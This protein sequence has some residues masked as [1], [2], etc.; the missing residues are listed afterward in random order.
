MSK[1]RPDQTEL[2]ETQSVVFLLLKKMLTL[3]CNIQTYGPDVREVR[4]NIVIDV[5][6]LV[7]TSSRPIFPSPKVYN[8]YNIYP[9]ISFDTD[10]I[11]N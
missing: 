4:G 5:D 9:I 3:V 8:F 7:S 10:A 1:S 11:R 2:N 6:I